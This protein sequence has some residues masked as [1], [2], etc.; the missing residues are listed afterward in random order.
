M[1]DIV[2]PHDHFFKELFTHKENAV[3]FV[4]HYL[5]S[6]VVKLFDLTTLEI[7]KDSFVDAALQELMSD[8]LYKVSLQDGQSAYIY[9]LFDH[10]SYEDALVSLQL[11]GY[12]VRIWEL[13]L[14]QEEEQRKKLRQ[15][16]RA[17]GDSP[18]LPKLSLPPIMPLVV[19]H[20]Q[21]Q[22]RVSTEFSGLFEL[23]TELQEYLPS[24]KYWLY[25]L[26][27]YDDADLKGAVMLQAGLL[28]LKYIYRPEL[29]QKLPEILDLIVKIADKQT[30]LT[31]LEALLRYLLSGAENLDKGT[32][33]ETV[34]EV[35]AEGGIIM[36]TIAEKLIEE[37]RAKG[38][39]EGLNRGLQEGLNKGLQEGLNKGRQEGLN[40]GLFKGRQEGLLFAINQI[41]MV[42]FKVDSGQYQERLQALSLSKLEQLSQR[43]VK[44][45]TLAEFE[46]ALERL[47]LGTSESWGMVNNN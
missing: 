8:L 14:K 17:H 4:R 9:L 42:Q 18:R 31:A 24:Y 45:K 20:G 30:G 1:T 22:W 28:A 12:M 36:G 38:L 41:L 44:A 6:Q 27:G 23:P 40:E 13:W 2:N 3:D 29:A 11:L 10:K 21:E 39:Q 46:E 16:R 35:L 15:E 5:P 47:L 43:V 7:C 32:L 19:Y 25:D 37:G 26:S 34:K 33:Q